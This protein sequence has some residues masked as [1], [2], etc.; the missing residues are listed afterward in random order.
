M[1]YIQPS[2]RRVNYYQVA[3]FLQ[4]GQIVGIGLDSIDQGC[5]TFE[6]SEDLGSGTY[7]FTATY[8]FDIPNSCSGGGSISGT[9][10]VDGFNIIPDCSTIAAD[11]NTTCQSTP[12]SSGELCIESATLNGVE[13][14]GL[15]ICE[16]LDA[17]LMDAV[18]NACQSGS[19]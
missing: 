7:N 9:A 11:C 12:G 5:P 6:Y 17:Q 15:P 13:Q 3:A 1:N 8:T 18:V 16:T 19:V 4:T 14:E 10:T 2:L